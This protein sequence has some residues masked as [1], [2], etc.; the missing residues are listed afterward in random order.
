MKQ[1]SRPD[2]TKIPPYILNHK[3]IINIFN[4][5]LYLTELIYVTIP[6]HIYP[7]NGLIINDLN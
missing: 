1:E 2:S 5:H 3:L 4:Y 7:L 6:K